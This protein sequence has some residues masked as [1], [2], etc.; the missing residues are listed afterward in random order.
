MR[1]ARGNKGTKGTEGDRRGQLGVSKAVLINWGADAAHRWDKNRQG[2]VD[3]MWLLGQAATRPVA[4]KVA[5]LPLTHSRPAAA[6][7][8]EHFSPTNQPTP[9][10]YPHS[11]QNTTAGKC[12][13]YHQQ[14]SDNAPFL[15]EGIS[16][17]NV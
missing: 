16:G 10:P 17:E 15:E 14:L 8:Q 11:T 12:A 4:E 6:A 7:W 3:P 2:L 9:Y 5:E 13:G 1:G